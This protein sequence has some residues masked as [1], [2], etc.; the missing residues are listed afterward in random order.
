MS[1]APTKPPTS[2]AATYRPA[3]GRPPRAADRRRVPARGAA[4]PGLGAAGQPG[5]RFTPRNADQG[6]GAGLDTP[7]ALIVCWTADGS[8][9]GHHGAAS[10]TGQA[11]R[12]AHAHGLGV[13]NLARPA[14]RAFAET[15]LTRT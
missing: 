4:P 10:G 14:H 13:V 5:A 7:A 1:S 8:L 2:W 11:L 15:F 9:D 3:A 6:L 12:V